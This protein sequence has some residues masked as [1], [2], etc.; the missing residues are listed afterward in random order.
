MSTNSIY[1]GRRTHAPCEVYVYVSSADRGVACRPTAVGW[2]IFNEQEIYQ[3][4]QVRA[5]P[6]VRCGE[7]MHI[8][9]R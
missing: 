4:L 7:V 3:Y 2:C 5:R 6:T 1:I 8:E 9:L